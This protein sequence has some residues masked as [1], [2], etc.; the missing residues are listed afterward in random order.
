MRGSH[1]SVS[2]NW[3]PMLL[4]SLLFRRGGGSFL[5]PSLE[6]CMQV[7][8]EGVG[9]E[10]GCSPKV[11]VKEVDSRGFVLK[12]LVPVLLGKDSLLPCHGTSWYP[13]SVRNRNAF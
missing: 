1:P 7:G 2:T 12:G 10:G 13:S 3:R 8:R 5:W 9:K 11:E 4:G 6:K